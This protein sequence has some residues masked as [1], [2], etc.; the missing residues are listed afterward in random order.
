MREN[1]MERNN[2]RDGERDWEG[3]GER[4][5]TVYSVV[6]LAAPPAPCRLRGKSVLDAPLPTVVAVAWAGRSGHVWDMR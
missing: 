4:E 5:R 6:R 2:G 3:A 1:A